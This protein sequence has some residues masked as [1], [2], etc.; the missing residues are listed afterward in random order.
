MKLD[1]DVRLT[2]TVRS[3]VNDAMKQ[4]GG[5]WQVVFEK[6]ELDYCRET[7]APTL[8]QDEVIAWTEQMIVRH[9]LT[10]AVIE[11]F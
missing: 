2:K 1:R 5:T 6:G 4:Y 11:W 7:L 8:T 9:G 10:S 3:R